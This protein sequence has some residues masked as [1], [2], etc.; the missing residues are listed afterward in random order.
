MHDVYIS[1]SG[2]DARAAQMLCAVL[3]E[4]GLRCWIA[5]R[6]IRP[7]ELWSQSIGMAIATARAFVLV[8]G[9][10]MRLPSDQRRRELALAQDKL[11]LL[12]AVGND[13][14]AGALGVLPRI[15]ARG[16]DDLAAAR[17]VVEWLGEKGIVPGRQATGVDWWR[18]PAMS[19]AAGSPPD[20][21]QPP[22]PSELLAL[23]TRRGYRFDNVLPAPAAPSSPAVA[24][25][26]PVRD[27]SRALSVRRQRNSRLHFALMALIGAAA[28]GFAAH[29]EKQIITAIAGL[30]K[31][32]IPPNVPAA[33]RSAESDLVDVSAFA[34]KT[35]TD[36][37][38]F[39]VQVFLH[40]LK[41]KR[42]AAN[43]AREMDDEAARHGFTTLDLPLSVGQQVGVVLECATVTIEEPA[44]LLRWRGEPVAAQ[45]SVRAKPDAIVRQHQFCARLS[46]EG[47]PAGTLRF[48][49]RRAA[50]ALPVSA[51][52]RPDAAP[53]LPETDAPVLLDTEARRYRYAFLSY[54]REDRARVT[55]TAQIL[56]TLGIG[57]FQDILSVEP[58][59][60]WMPRIYR[61]IDRSDVFMLFWSTAASRSEWVAKET[62]YALDRQAA[63]QRP[64]VRPVIIEGPPVPA[65][66]E[67]L[68]SIHFDD[69]LIYVMSGFGSERRPS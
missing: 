31:F 6:D 46:V 61:E 23:R 22:Q 21:Y 48:A 59:E 64:D 35:V 32:S 4:H 53:P 58:G 18:Q 51:A 29:F 49:I 15:D 20:R 60:K 47:V 8:L 42:E 44:E 63:R 66:P 26:A 17:R 43:L 2:Q 41:Q 16:E 37:E 5:S 30:L 25:A 27:P 3:E 1:Y 40:A 55:Q 65:P 28:L 67:K 12:F 24:R 36:D 38:P 19:A 34:P 13:P 45:F 57:F 7:G 54:S 52:G 10:E 62:Q 68:A 9:N 11:V 56:R 39:L 33:K 50:T 14:A 69:P